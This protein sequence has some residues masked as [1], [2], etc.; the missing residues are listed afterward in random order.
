[1]TGD[2]GI[3]QLQAAQEKDG[4]QANAPGY[5]LEEK[6]L[7]VP[8]VEPARLFGPAAPPAQIVVDMYAGPDP[9]VELVLPVGYRGLVRTKVH[10]L[11]DLPGPPGQRLF[12]YETPES[13]V[14]QVTGS[15]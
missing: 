10:I 6:S 2:D 12:R 9:T 13:G 14:V 5:M 1:M 3:T 8:P 4:F 7:A 15:A 11:D